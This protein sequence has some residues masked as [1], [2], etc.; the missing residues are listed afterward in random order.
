MAL[1]LKKK[2]FD[3]KMFFAMLVLCRLPMISQDSRKSL[4]YLLY[5]S[6]LIF[7]I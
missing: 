3:P 5:E 6:I 7:D 1:T 4:N 2:V